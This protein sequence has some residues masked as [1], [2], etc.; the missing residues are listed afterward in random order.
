MTTTAHVARVYTSTPQPRCT[1]PQ[2]PLAAGLAPAAHQAAAHMLRSVRDVSRHTALASRVR[3][4]VRAGPPVVGFAPRATLPIWIWPCAVSGAHGDLSTGP[5]SS[6]CMDCLLRT[7]RHHCTEG[8]CCKCMQAAAIKAL[9]LAC[10][11]LGT[12]RLCA[13]GA[14]VP[15]WHVQARVLVGSVGMWRC[16]D[17]HCSHTHGPLTI[18]AHLHHLSL[19]KSMCAY[20]LSLS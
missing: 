1:H 5:M 4:V 6:A 18:S 8:S 17:A 20:C 10:K 11:S 7:G 19:N 3:G 16:R 15:A 13:L 14:G 9:Q 2:R 12:R